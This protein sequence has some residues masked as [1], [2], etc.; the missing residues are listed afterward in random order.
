MKNPFNKNIIIK[1]CPN[2][3]KIT[4]NVWDYHVD[5]PGLMGDCSHLIDSFGAPYS[6]KSNE[7]VWLTDSCPHESRI[8]EKDCNRQWFRLVTSEVGIWYSK[9]ST[10]NRLGIKPNC[11]MVDYFKF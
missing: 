7:L 8:I 3:Y 9:H 10:A 1:N 6:L 2:I 5:T 11:E 4:C